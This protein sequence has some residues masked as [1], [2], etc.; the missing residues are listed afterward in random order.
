MT[1]EAVL[2]ILKA[3]KPFLVQSMGVKAIG[4]FG[5]LARGEATE[6]S[7]IDILVELDTP[8]F[9]KLMAVKIFLEKQLSHPVDLHR[10]GPYLRQQFLKAIESEIVYA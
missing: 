3:Q 7:D 4:L 8:D 5:S 9:Q 2:T 6:S 10:K 1:R